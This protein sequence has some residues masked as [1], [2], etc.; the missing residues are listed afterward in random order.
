MYVVA[1]SLIELMLIF[2]VGFDFDWARDF[3]LVATSQRLGFTEFFFLFF[4]LAWDSPDGE[5]KLVVLLLLLL[6]SRCG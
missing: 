2:F 6:L 3:R 1:A 4:L 5:A